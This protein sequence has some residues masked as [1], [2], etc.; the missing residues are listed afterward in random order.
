MIISLKIKNYT[1]L[2]DVFIEFKKGLTVISGETGSGKSIILDALGLVLGKRVERFSIDKTTSQSIIEAVFSI[3]ETKSNFFN[4]YDIDFQELTV[5][6][7]ELNP[8]GKSKAYINGTP[9]LV[10]VLSEFGNQVVEMHY[11]NQSTL[12][13]DEFSQFDLID[14]LAR[15][16]KLL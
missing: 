2:K 9:V 5:V 3:E 4:K 1:L 13:K 15:S 7:R 16:E 10:N 14:K 11:Q 6:R 8:S 12:L